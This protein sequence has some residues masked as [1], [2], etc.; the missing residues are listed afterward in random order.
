[1]PLCLSGSWIAKNEGGTRWQ[2]RGKVHKPLMS[3]AAAL[4]DASHF[5]REMRNA[6]EDDEVEEMSY[7][8]RLAAAQGELAAAN[9]AAAKGE[10]A[11]AAAGLQEALR[12]LRDVDEDSP[13]EAQQLR[14][15]VLEASRQVFARGAARVMDGG[16]GAE[17]L[18]EGSVS[19]AQM[20]HA[21]CQAAAGDDALAPALFQ[22][23]PGVLAERAGARVFCDAGGLPPLLQLCARQDAMCSSHALEALH[24]LSCIGLMVPAICVAGKQC[25]DGRNC[26]WWLRR[27]IHTGA[28]AAQRMSGLSILRNLSDTKGLDDKQQAAVQTDLRNAITSP[29]ADTPSDGGASQDMIAQLLALLT[30]ATHATHEPDY[31]LVHL[32]CTCFRNLARDAGVRRH[33]ASALSVLLGVCFRLDDVCFRLE[34]LGT[35]CQS[36]GGAGSGTCKTGAPLLATGTCK[37][38]MHSNSADAQ[39]SLLA[40]LEAVINCMTNSPENR[41]AALD[42]SKVIT[43][44]FSHAKWGVRLKTLQPPLI[45][46]GID[47]E[48]EAARAALM[49]GDIV[50]RV[51][52]DL[53]H[54]PGLPSLQQALRRGGAA[55]VQL[56]RTGVGIIAGNDSSLCLCGWAWG[57]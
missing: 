40:A 1:M 43:C 25:G 6:D 47:A 32:L 23:L 38:D 33:F 9:A 5:S 46:T 41:L 28:P 16:A 34:Y 4:N 53:D 30:A 11:T 54:G 39:A 56:Q 18:D 22:S 12:F 10:L 45:L 35:A 57:L 48:S 15:A 50:V 27:S 17:A 8:D 37:T 26:L 36:E 7:R 49:P 55:E 42:A 21:L 13:K 51:G 29:H 44:H 52:D 24:A 20:A 19:P 31:Q 2:G 3:A 14:A